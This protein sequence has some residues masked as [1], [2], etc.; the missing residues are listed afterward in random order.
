MRAAKQQASDLDH[1]EKAFNDLNSPAKEKSPTQEG[2]SPTDD[3]KVKQGNLKPRSIRTDNLAR[4]S[5][6]PAP[7]PQH[8]LPEKPDS[9]KSTSL[10]PLSLGNYLKRS[11]TAKPG[12]ANTSP[13]KAEGG[14]VTDQLAALESVRRDL[15]SQRA[16]VKE[17]EDMLK[18]EKTAR[19][20][21]EERARRIELSLSSKPVAVVQEIE[22]PSSSSESRSLPPDESAPQEP[23]SISKSEEG[24]QQRLDTMVMEMQKMKSDMVRYQQRAESAEA[25]ASKTRESLA[26]M[27]ERL[28]QENEAETAE[29]IEA[30]ATSTIKPLKSRSSDS[31]LSGSESGT[32][33]K[34]SSRDTANGHVSTPKIPSHLEQAVATALRHSSSGNG[35]ALAQSAPYV[36]MLGVVLIGVGLM[37]YLNSWQK[38]EK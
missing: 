35:E 5:E 6:P 32:K 30:V 26:E 17:L 11:D 20:E 37:A 13:S 29:D 19:I 9:A 2:P 10:N 1:I 24:L 7:P 21:A 25:E 27:I 33:S 38:T 4:F 36:S 34:K 14:S 22:E 18:D 16:R 15:D 8:P 3:T 28:R 31:T 23:A 12:S